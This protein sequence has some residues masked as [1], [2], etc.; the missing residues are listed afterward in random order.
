MHT[1]RDI[2]CPMSVLRVNVCRYSQTVFIILL[3]H[4]SS[5][6]ST[7]PLLNSKGNPLAGKLNIR[8]HRPHPR[9][10]P[11]SVLFAQYLS[12]VPLCGTHTSMKAYTHWGRLNGKQLSLWIRTDKQCYRD[13]ESTRLGITCWSQTSTETCTS[14]QDNQPP[15]NCLCR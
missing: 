2:F 15:S 3:G 13:A 11:T 1:E 14:V 12:M 4:H 6:L 9:K 7:P 5:L 10:L 8:T